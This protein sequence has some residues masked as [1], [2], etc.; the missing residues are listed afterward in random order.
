V[1]KHFHLQVGPDRLATLIWD[2]PDKKVNVFGLEVFEELQALLGELARRSDIGCLILLSGKKDNFIAGADVNLIAEVTD[3]AR[4]EEGVRLGQRLFSTWEALPFPTVAAIRG[5]CV[6][7]GLEI[8]LAS[9]YRVVS[10]RADIRL[11]LPEI[12]L[13][14]LPAWG[15]STRLP[16]LI[17]VPAA[18]DMILT[19]KNV[20]PRSAFK[21]G[22]VDALLPDA[23]FLTL[24]RD[25]ASARRDKK[26]RPSHNAGLQGLLLQGNPLG[27]MVLFS[28]ARKQVLGQTKG[29]Y[30]APLKALEVV[31]TGLEKGREAG[32]EA[33][34]KAAAELAVSPICKNLVNVFRLMEGAKKAGPK[35]DPPVVPPGEV[36]VLG[37]GTMGG[38]IA[39]LLAD[40]ANTPVRLKDLAPKALEGGMAHASSLFAK[41]VKRRRLT[42]AEARRKM[43]LLR[44]TLVDGGYRGVDL[45]IE[46]IV[47]KL[48][49]KQ[50]VFAD[51]ATK[52]PAETVLASNTSSLSIDLIGA[53][54]PH[55]ERVVGMHFFNP[56]DKMPLIEVIRGAKTSDRAAAAV[57]ELSKRL[58]KTPVLVKDG[59]GF[60]VN[61]LLMFYSLEA[62]WLLDEGHRIEDID[63]AMTQWGMPLGPITLTDEVG[64]DVAV[65]VA[66]I[67]AE[68]FPDRLP[69]PSWLDRSA[70]PDRLGAKTA[71]GFYLYQERKR[72]GPD[73]AIYPLLGLQP[74]IANPNLATLAER[75]V[76]PMVNE[77]ARCLAE[78]V[79]ADA[80]SLDLAMIMGTGFPPFRGGLC[81]WADGQ[82]LGNVLETL[83][84]LA[85]GVGDRFRPS[86]ALREAAL[87]GGFYARWPVRSTD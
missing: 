66:H 4:A 30:P 62:L 8:S 67:L 26:Q 72:T 39:H 64:I 7:G 87:A 78:D 22:L 1:G 19:G 84:R 50:N 82:G 63:K 69:L 3:V 16:R 54:T 15:G 38:G 42:A 35:V 24:V 57:F 36:L 73:P 86:E 41:Q 11:G 76:L 61:R 51:L 18:L 10:D 46:A 5:T 71:K 47:E 12:R 58:G 34:A 77:A 68:A 74:R 28:Q 20:S 25:F 70:E 29:Q 37:A 32:F 65:K 45:V 33:E 2:S 83:E 85:T 40:A 75:M 13:G 14:I 21:S 23:A 17:G 79:V 6:G 9:T 27:R 60:L 59:P 55:P 80:G 48:E 43:A 44:P 53:K 31:R 49:V 56:V 52:V 81:R